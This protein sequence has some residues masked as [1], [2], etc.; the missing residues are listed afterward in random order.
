MLPNII[1]DS[2]ASF[3]ANRRA[4]DHA[5]LVQKVISHF[6]KMKEKTGN[7]AV[8]ID[9]E[10]AFDRIEW[11]FIKETLEYFN[12]PKCCP[13]SSCLVSPPTLFKSFSMVDLQRLSTLL[14]ES[15]NET[16]CPLTSSSCAWRDF[17]VQFNSLLAQK[18]GIP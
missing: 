14:V 10:K 9:L 17:P 11:P 12:I 13:N 1:G 18:S 5:I 6:Q 15:G 7:M 2:Q 4:S 16:L 3:L 8:K